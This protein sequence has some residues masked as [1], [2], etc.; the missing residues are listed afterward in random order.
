MSPRPPPRIFTVESSNTSRFR[1]PNLASSTSREHLQDTPSPRQ[2]NPAARIRALAERHDPL[3]SSSGK[4]EPPGA[5]SML[6]GVAADPERLLSRFAQ[7]RFDISI[8]H[9]HTLNCF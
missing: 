7:F 4:K 3:T 2:S 8:T 1:P 5:F 6:Q 9:F